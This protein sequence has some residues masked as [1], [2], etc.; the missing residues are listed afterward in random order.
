MRKVFLAA[1]LSG[2]VGLLGFAVQPASQAAPLPQA[3][4]CSGVWVVVDYGSLGGG[5][6]TKCATSFDTGTKA[7]KSAGFK[8]TIEGGFIYKINGKPSKPDI[9]KEYWSYWHASADSDGSFSAW[10]Y[11]NKGADGYRPTKGNAEGWRYQALAD[12][13]V[14]PSKKPPVT[15]P[16]PEPTK[17]TAKPSATKKPTATA[18]PTATRKP[19]ATAKPTTTTTPKK[20]A[21]P[22]SPS[23]ASPST[24]ITESP[25]ASPTVIAEPSATTVISEADLPPDEPGTPIG[26]IVAGVL[27]V[28]GGA[29]L[30]SWWWLKG[31]RL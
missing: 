31:R 21:A 22:S 7:L 27:I 23:T 10:T 19:T 4:S 14:P 16:D 13:K 6:Q 25:A 17:P 11:S 1:L 18:K 3:A 8:V 9:N 5:V 26:A 29:G 28:G 20:S 12:G 30:G 15:K 2:L 24:A